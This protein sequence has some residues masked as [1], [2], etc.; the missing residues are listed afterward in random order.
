MA[1]RGAIFYSTSALAGSF[2]GLIAYGIQKNIDGQNGWHS[3]QWLYLVEGVLP[4]GCSFII[5]L[6]LP[7]TPEKRHFLFTKEEQDL[8]VRRSRRAFN[9]ENPKFRPKF[10]LKPLKKVRF[11]LLVAIYAFNH[12]S[13]SS[14]NNFLPAII[15]VRNMSLYFMRAGARYTTHT[16]IICCRA[17][18]IPRCVRS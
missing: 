2:N 7:G 5:L 13:V 1:T 6:L 17:L 16:D 11:W 8:A 12:Y 18:A 14:L 10:I 9:P 3:W 4:M 15:R